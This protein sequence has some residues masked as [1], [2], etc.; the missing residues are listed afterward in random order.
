MTDRT[1]PSPVS[2]IS[3]LTETADLKVR[4]TYANVHTAK[5]PNGEIRGQKLQ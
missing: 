4:K 5:N 2:G 1:V 3:T